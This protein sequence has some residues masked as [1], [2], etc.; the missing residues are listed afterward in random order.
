MGGI[1]AAASQDTP[2]QSFLWGCLEISATAAT[3]RNERLTSTGGNEGRGTSEVVR[4]SRSVGAAG[5][6][7]GTNPV[8]EAGARS[9]AHEGAGWGGWWKARGARAGGAAC[10]EGA[11]ATTGRGGVR[12]ARDEPDL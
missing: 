1:N 4:S 11:P 2:A 5:T 9:F 3:A 8:P 7:S 12:R 10:D 6:G